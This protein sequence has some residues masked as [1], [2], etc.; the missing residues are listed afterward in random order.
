MCDLL[1]LKMLQMDLALI[2][3]KNHNLFDPLVRKCQFYLRFCVL[4]DS[5]Q[6]P[7]KKENFLTYGSK[8]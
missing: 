6:F 3:T 2:K 7:I 4:N 8:R 5:S 1:T